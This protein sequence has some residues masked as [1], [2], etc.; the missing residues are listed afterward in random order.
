MALFSIADVTDARLGLDASKIS[1]AAPKKLTNGVV[2]SMHYDGKPLILK[3]PRLVCPFD[4]TRGFKGK[5]GAGAAE[6]KESNKTEIS[7]NVP[8]TPANAALSSALKVVNDAIK[9]HIEREAPTIFGESGLNLKPKD[10]AD[11][12]KAVQ[13]DTLKAYY[14]LRTDDEKYAPKLKLKIPDSATM[15]NNKNPPQ[16]ISA[17]EIKRNSSVTAYFKVRG[18]FANSLLV[19]VQLEAAAL[20][21]SG[22]ASMDVKDLFADDIEDDDTTPGKG[23]KRSRDDDD[24][25]EY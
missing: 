25:E 7:L 23:T 14:A 17:E 10:L 13:S 9:S 19:S 1:F 4:V 2:V 24:K 16:S 21:V 11:M 20:C 12:L 5:D 3:T 8:D 6:P 18:F 22:S 15:V